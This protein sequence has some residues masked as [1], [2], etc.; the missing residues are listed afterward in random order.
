MT[1]KPP[2]LIVLPLP[3]EASILVVALASAIE[4]PIETP[5]ETAT[6]SASASVCGVAVAV[7]LSELMPRLNVE[8]L[9]VLAVIVESSEALTNAVSGFCF[10]YF[11]R[12][13]CRLWCSC[14]D[15]RSIISRFRL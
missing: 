14:G 13:C 5:P 9:A 10:R 11:L 7:T 15:Y 3:T 1:D 12:G 6:P 2:A 4:A 8:L